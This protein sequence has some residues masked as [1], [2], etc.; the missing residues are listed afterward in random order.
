[1]ELRQ[2]GDARLW[3]LVPTFPARIRTFA[4][5]IPAS[6]PMVIEWEEIVERKTFTVR[7]NGRTTRLECVTEYKDWSLWAESSPEKV[8]LIWFNTATRMR[9]VW[10]ELKCQ[11]GG[12]S[13]IHKPQ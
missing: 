5:S 8:R 2:L 6:P 1:M 10:K 3:E 11:S 9:V 4:W 7:E 13:E 12:F